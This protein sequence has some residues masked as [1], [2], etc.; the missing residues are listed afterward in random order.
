MK[1]TRLLAIFVALLSLTTVIACGQGPQSPTASNTATTGTM[2]ETFNVRST[3][4]AS[5]DQALT[6]FGGTLLQ[7]DAETNTS[8][9]RSGTG[10]ITK[11]INWTTPCLEGGTRAVNGSVTL[12]RNGDGTGSLMTDLHLTFTACDL[13]RLTLQGDPEVHLTG[14]ATFVNRLPDTH[15]FHKVGA[16]LFTPADGIQGRVRFDCT[17]TWSRS[18]G[19]ISRTGTVTWEKPVGTPISGP[20]CTFS[21]SR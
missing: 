4:Q 9:P 21:I 1:A 10:T 15:T 20:G 13:G 8:T 3:V 7:L 12:T 16:V 11:T 14:Q 6:L 19:V 17:V 2:S 5:S 18:T